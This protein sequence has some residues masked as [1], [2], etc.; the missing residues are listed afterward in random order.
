MTSNLD[1]VRYFYSNNP[2]DTRG[3]L[4]NKYFQSDDINMNL[5]D[6]MLAQNYDKYENK[7]YGY[8]DIH[9]EFTDFIINTALHHRQIELYNPILPSFPKLDIKNKNNI[10]DIKYKSTQLV[11]F[12]KETPLSD[13][14][15]NI[16]YINIYI[17]EL[18][19]KLLLGLYITV[20]SYDL[21][22]IV[23][24]K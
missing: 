24:Y 3:N 8:N 7:G 10:T 13:Y 22:T 20:G 19:Y 18:I 2:N 4:F 23:T 6:I 16:D 5:S 11:I 12:T 1:N 9:L 17:F 15:N 21:N 14:F